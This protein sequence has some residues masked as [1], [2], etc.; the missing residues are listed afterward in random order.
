MYMKP[1]SCSHHGG[2]AGLVSNTHQRGAP[3]GRAAEHSALGEQLAGGSGTEGLE[4]PAGEVL[5]GGSAQLHQHAALTRVGAPW[6]E[7]I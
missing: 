7:D 3:S 4:R 1:H 6:V 2:G 5:L